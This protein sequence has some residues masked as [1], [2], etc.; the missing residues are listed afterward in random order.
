MT[1]DFTL[2][3]VTVCICTFNRA[4]LLDNTLRQFTTLRVPSGLSWELVVINNNSTDH[5]TDVLARYASQLPMRIFNEAKQGHSHA[6]NRGLA[7]A[8][9]AWILYTDDDVQIDEGWLETFVAAV[10]RRPEVAVAGGPIEPWFPQ[11]VDPLLSEVFPELREGFCGLDHGTPER[12]LENNQ[13]V[14]GANFALHRDR[15][16]SLHFDPNL[17]LPRRLNEETELIARVRAAG[18]TVLWIPDMRVRHYVDPSRMT[19]AYL[20]RYR[21]IRG[22]TRVSLDGLDPAPSLFGAPRW[23]LRKWAAA[24][25]KSIGYRLAGRRR[26][27]LEQTREYSFYQGMINQARANRVGVRAR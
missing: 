9:F 26:E 20:R 23:L 2:P 19:L 21:A 12:I 10:T 14:F 17:G 7:E 13:D 25:V 4:A 1:N 6:R 16:G 22:A 18:G 11:P 5:T 8:H 3:S 15:I 27:S 24:Y